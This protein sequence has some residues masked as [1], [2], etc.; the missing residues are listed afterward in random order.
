MQRPGLYF[1]FV[2]VR[3]DEWL[4]AAALYWPSVHRLVPRGYDTHDTHTAQVFAEHDIL[5]DEDPGDLIFAAQWDLASGLAQQASRLAESFSVQRAHEDWDGR[6]WAEAGGPDWEIPALGWVHATKFPPDVVEVLAQAGLAVMGRREMEW[7]DP[8]HPE[9]WLGLH[10]A[11]AGAYMK[12]LAAKLSEA[13]FFEPLTDQA[14]LRVATP[15]S[16]VQGALQLLLGPDDPSQTGAPDVGIETYMMLALQHVQPAGLEQVPA[17][18]IVACR[19]NL[20]DELETFRQFLADQQQELAGLA[21]VPH[22]RRRLEAFAAHVAEHV[23][24]PLQQ[25]ERGLRLHRLEPTRSLLLAGSVAP[26]AALGATLTLVGADPAATVVSGT[27]IAVGAAWWQVEAT[28]RQV[29]QQSPVA[30]LLD[31]RDELTPK[32][33]VSRAR[34]LLT[35]TYA[36]RGR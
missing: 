3:D 12:A 21:S 4:K 6:R 30:F 34:R 15:T 33:V 23:E 32:T 20:E 14:D 26:P 13:A 35:G 17:E 5:R 1:P 29:K 28:R 9:E 36:Q 10:P 18:C 22:E 31:M 16:G 8:G 27:A 7:R 2:H 24:R 11:L 25:L 19:Q